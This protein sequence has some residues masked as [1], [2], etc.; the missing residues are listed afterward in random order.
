L[1][2][3]YECSVY[4]SLNLALA[5]SQNCRFVTADERLF[6]ALQN[7]ELEAYIQLL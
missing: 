1:A 6:N 7:S 2:L 5:V 3:V 4:D